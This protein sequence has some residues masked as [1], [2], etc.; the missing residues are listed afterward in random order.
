MDADI[1]EKEDQ[2]GEEEEAVFPGEVNG[3]GKPVFPWY[4]LTSGTKVYMKGIPEEESVDT[5]EYP[6]LIPGRLRYT[7]SIMSPVPPA[8]AQRTSTG[9]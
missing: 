7:F 4:L 6:V 9:W 3:A 1:K 8:T 2:E 5:E